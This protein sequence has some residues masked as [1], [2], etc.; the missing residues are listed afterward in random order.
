MVVHFG[1]S[2]ALPPAASSQVA[3]WVAAAAASGA[4]LH[5]GCATGADAL[6]IQSALAAGLAGRLVVFA[7]FGPGGAGACG[8]SAVAAVSA[9]AQAGAQVRWWAGGSLRVPLAGRLAC[10]SRA[11][12][13]GAA[14]C[15]LFSPGS[16]SLAA[17][18][19][20][21]LAGGAAL[22]A[23]APAAPAAPAGCAGAW[24]PSSHFGL[25]CWR[26][27]PAQTTLF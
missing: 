14:L 26:W 23:I 21:A 9:A 22:L 20:A 25:P 17:A 19:P 27:Q 5:T 13:R 1:G 16:G 8:V 12:V 15:V 10:R 6:V 11:A 18:A 3:A 24:Q 2:R 4:G 7:A